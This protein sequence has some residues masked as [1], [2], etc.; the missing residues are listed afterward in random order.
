MGPSV[1]EGVL[2]TATG[3]HKGVNGTPMKGRF[4]LERGRSPQVWQP[5]CACEAVC[6][7]LVRHDM[8]GIVRWHQTVNGTAGLAKKPQT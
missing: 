6:T 3:G 1:L 8:A 4:R 7:T 5:A 2:W